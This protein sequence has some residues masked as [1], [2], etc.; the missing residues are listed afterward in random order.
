MSG[1]DEYYR[2][3]EVPRNATQDDIRRAYRRLALRWHPDKNP[4]NKDDA[5]KRFKAIA[6]AYEVLS[7]ETKRRQYD[8]YGPSGYD[9][10][11]QTD[12]GASS[13]STSSRHGG[14]FSAFRDPE[15]LFREFFGTSDPFEELFRTVRQGSASMHPHAKSSNPSR[16]SGGG[17][18]VQTGG[19][20]S[21]HHC[22]LDPGRIL[23]PGFFFDLDDLLFGACGSVPTGPGGLGFP[24]QGGFAGLPTEQMSSVRYSNGKRCE[25]RTIVQDGVKTVLCFEDGRM[26]SRTVNG[27]SQDVPKVSDD[28]RDDSQQGAYSSSAS[29]KASESGSSP[30]S[31][32]G[33]ARQAKSG[34]SVGSDLSPKVGGKASS[35]S[36]K[37][38]PTRQSSKAHKSRS[39]TAS[40]SAIKVPRKEGSEATATG[41]PA[42][43]PQKPPNQTPTPTPTPVPPPQQQQPNAQAA[44]VKRKP[45]KTGK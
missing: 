29:H 39:H 33:A 14:V 5:E 25:T 26:V 20:P 10:S 19:S 40:K 6:E 12:V 36:N 42:N 9:T 24:S 18:S 43:A 44:G 22:G 27:V 37:Q 8:L 35:H 32:E 16:P 15:E 17:G 28:G 3:L 1:A 23:R 13:C 21:F 45:S 34:K 31:A 7:D 41:A 2:A 38:P 11:Q 4:D 30:H